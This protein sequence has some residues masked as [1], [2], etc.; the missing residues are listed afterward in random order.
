MGLTELKPIPY[1]KINEELFNPVNIPVFIKGGCKNMEA[2][3]KWDDLHYLKEKM[4]NANVDVET[5]KSSEDY[6]TS[7][8]DIKNM[9]FD[10]Y[11]ENMKANIYLPDCSLVKLKGES[12][13]HHNIFNDLENTMDEVM[14]LPEIPLDYFLFM[15]INT[16]SGCHCHVEEDFIVNQIVGTKRFYLM[17]Y[18][19]LK[20][21]HILH[22][23]NN[24]SKKSFWELDRD[25]YDI[26]Y[27]DLEPGDM[28][29]IPPWWWH[30]VR[31]NDLTIA[32]T[33]IYQR[34]DMSYL[35]LKGNKSLKRRYWVNSKI[36][37]IIENFYRRFL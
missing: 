12:N 20:P 25:K 1:N 19:E 15:G 14:G 3:F 10:K 21:N 23:R 22:K 11:I 5:Y 37:K 24:F 34:E 16:K 6:K 35:N 36:P 30:A 2:R 17:N 32:V 33:K 27:V 8:A 18:K 13:I 29:T 9:G 26:Y 4:N 28:L 31:S 7:N